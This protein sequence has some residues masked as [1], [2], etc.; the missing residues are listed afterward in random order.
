MPTKNENRMPQ[1]L[2]ELQENSWEVELLI[3]GGAIFALVQ[4]DGALLEL[5]KSL[6]TTNFFPGMNIFFMLSM[7]TIKTL[8]LGFIFHLVLRAIWLSFICINYVFP[9]G[10][11]FDKLKLKKPY[12]VT[13]SDNADLYEQIIKVDKASGL[14]IFF[15]ILSTIVFI[16]IAIMVAVFSG[17][18]RGLFWLTES[19]WTN[20]AVDFMWVIAAIYY[21]DF[22][23]FG[24]LRKIPLLTYLTFPVFKLLDWISLRFVFERALRILNT[25]TSKTRVVLGTI[26]FFIISLLFT[27]SSI[28]SRMKWPNIFDQRKYRWALAPGNASWTYFYGYYRDQADWGVIQSDIIKENYLRVYIKYDV[29]LDTEIEKLDSADQYLS[30]IGEVGIDDSVITDIE[31]FSAW[32]KENENMGIVANIP[33]HNLKN[34]R[35][36]L[37]FKYVSSIDSAGKPIWKHQIPFWKDVIQS[38]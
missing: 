30:N 27:T 26:I 4:G 2:K 14:I 7:F 24:I 32:Q 1:W 21:V 17:F 35:H 29:Q 33:I 38:Q 31:W 9:R 12:K 6:R 34:G 23:F 5:H 16:G 28:Y 13:S 3:S 18:E 11:Q 20:V 10:I 25:N 37:K 22:L 15:S 36:T 19:D 8:T